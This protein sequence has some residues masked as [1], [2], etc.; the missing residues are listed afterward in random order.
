MKKLSALSKRK[1]IYQE[2]SSLDVAQTEYKDLQN[3][4]LR[5]FL[6]WRNK[7]LGIT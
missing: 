2:L 1:D 4:T 6:I 5:D 3:A 7:A